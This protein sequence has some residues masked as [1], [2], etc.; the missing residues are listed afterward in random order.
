MTNTLFTN[1]RIIGLSWLHSP[2]WSFALF[3]CSR[4]VIEGVYIYTSLYE[5]VWAD[6]ID[7]VSCHD[8]SISDS[9][10]ETGDD[11]IAIVCGIPEWGPDY[12]TENLTITNCRFSSASA[13]AP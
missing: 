9:T 10:I 4:V 2:S 8:I 3:A 6:G 7:I 11:C 13:P 1:V 12:P 5:A